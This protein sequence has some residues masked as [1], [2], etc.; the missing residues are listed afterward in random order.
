MRTSIPH[1]LGRDEARRRLR[2]GS[3]KLG[4]KLPPQIGDIAVSW[5]GEDRMDL[6]ISAMGQSIP[7]HVEIE[8][9]RLVVEV[10]LP[11]LLAMFEAP[12]EQAVR[13]NG[14]KLLGSR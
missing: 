3:A 4:G 12:I 9:D 7:G 1:Q 13:D 8:D 14:M 11:P 2:E 6:A 10:T 5:P